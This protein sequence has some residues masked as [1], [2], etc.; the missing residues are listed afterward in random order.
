M[1][2]HCFF[3]LLIFENGLFEDF[4]LYISKFKTCFNSCSK[5]LRT[6]IHQLLSHAIGS[7]QEYTK[8]EQTQREDQL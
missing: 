8:I 5:K 2:F 1:R 6:P 7:I 4:I 3:E